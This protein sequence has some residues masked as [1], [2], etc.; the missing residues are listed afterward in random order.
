MTP[1]IKAR[2][3]ADMARTTSMTLAELVGFLAGYSARFDAEIREGVVTREAVR[4]YADEA[5]GRQ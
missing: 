1:E 4:A 2:I 5:R 3:E